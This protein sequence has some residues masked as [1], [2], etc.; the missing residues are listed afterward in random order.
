MDNMYGKG[1]VMGIIKKRKKIKMLDIR[2]IILKVKNFLYRFN[3][4]NIVG[5]IM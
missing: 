5:E 3:M 1:K 4:L 2:N